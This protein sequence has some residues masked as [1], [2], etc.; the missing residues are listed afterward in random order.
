VLVEHTD[1]GAFVLNGTQIHL[2]P[3]AW[4][5]RSDHRTGDQLARS[6]ASS[7]RASLIEVAHRAY[8]EALEAS[9]DIATA[10]GAA[11]AAMRAADS[12]S[13]VDWEASRG[14]LGG[15]I[16][17]RWRE[18]P[19]VDYDIQLVPERVSPEFARTEELDRQYATALWYYLCESP[20]TCWVFVQEDGTG[21]AYCGSALVREIEAQLARAYRGEEPGDY[22]LAAREVGAIL[23]AAPASAEE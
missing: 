9:F 13:L 12:D 19:T 11:F 21:R 20:E 7:R 3:W 16:V 1:E 15:S 4:I 17:V 5:A 22:P 23:S 2:A 10:S 18:R 6:E 14:P 8:E